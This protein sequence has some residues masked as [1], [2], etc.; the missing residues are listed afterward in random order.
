[1]RPL[2][3]RILILLAVIGL[4]AAPMLLT[5][6]A[7]LRRAESALAAGR[8]LDAVADFEHVARLL[9]WRDGLWE[10]SGRAAFAGGDM[11]ES[12][13]LLKQAP[14]LSVEGWAELGAAYYQLGQFDESVCAFQRG[15]EL[16]GPAASLYR[17]LVLAFNAQGDLQA[18]TSALQNYITLE[19]GEAAARYRLGMLLSLL[20]SENALSELMASAQLDEAYDPAVQTMRTTLNLAALEQNEARRLVVTGRGLGLVQEWK[21]AREAFQRATLTEPNYA[22]AWAWLGEAKQHLG[23]GGRD[24]LQRAE[25]LDP[26]SANVRALFGLYWKRVDEPALAL[27]EFQWAAIIEPDNP[28][29]QAALGD[30]YI[31]AGDLP[32]ALAA[33]QRAAELAPKD[34]AYWRLLATFCRQYTYQIEEVGIPAAAQVLALYPDEAASHDLLGWM[35]LSVNVPALAEAEFLSALRLDPNYAAAHLHLGMVYIELNKKDLARVHL[36]QAQ[37]LDPQ[38]ADGMMAAQLLAQFFP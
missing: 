19:D 1:M 17:G 28:A 36:V 25:A 11:A 4:I 21:L 23:Q 27:A 7:E 26:F 14:A 15:L 5:A 13:R 24:E 18:E 31:Q 37:M 3:Y 38:G 8:P 12:I 10:R 34:A 29:F 16:H 2:L 9:F 30:A 20:D 35:Y 6:N 22:E 33:Y 32:P